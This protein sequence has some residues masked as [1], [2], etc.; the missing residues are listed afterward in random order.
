MLPPGVAW[1]LQTAAAVA[2]GDAWLAPAERLVQGGL[3][4]PRRRGQWRLGRWTAKRALADR[5]GV[6]PQELARLE[7]RA[8]SDGAPEA[9]LDGTALPLVL[10]LSHCADHGLAALAAEGIA[11]GADLEKV[12]ARSGAFVREFFTPAEQRWLAELSADQQAESAT[13][14]WSAKES[15]LKALRTGLRRDTRSVEVRRA[16]ALRVAP[17]GAA[18]AP[19]TALT[20]RDLEGRRSF[21]GVWRRVGERVLTLVADP[22]EGV[23]P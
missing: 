6:A 21:S 12:E 14:I 15:A 9:Q 3:L 1:L 7:V 5:L 13:L 23:L 18:D 17:S 8:A 20:V 19:W 11:L 22:W 16:P 10:S 2:E 4:L